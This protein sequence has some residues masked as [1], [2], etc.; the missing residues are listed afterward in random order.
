[1]IW[2]YDTHFIEVVYLS[3][4]VTP[5]VENYSPLN[6]GSWTAFGCCIGLVGLPL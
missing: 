2:V 4:Q 6:E 3:F 1:M 5:G